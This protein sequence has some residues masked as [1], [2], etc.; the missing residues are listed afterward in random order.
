MGV[1]PKSYRILAQDR[2]PFKPRRL[3]NKEGRHIGA[4]ERQQQKRSQRD[5][6]ERFLGG[7]GWT[8]TTDSAI[9]SRLLCLLSYV[10]ISKPRRTPGLLVAGAGFEPATFGL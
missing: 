1:T 10:A 5:M 2:C 3:I 4:D 8:R 6:W 7:D 9:M